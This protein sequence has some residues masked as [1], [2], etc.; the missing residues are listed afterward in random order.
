MLKREPNHREALGAKGHLLVAEGR[1]QEAVSF[2][3]KAAAGGDA[4]L[5][6]ALASARLE[7]GDTRGAREAASRVLATSPN[8]PW[9]LT[10]LGASLV[11][12]GQREEGLR[13]LRRAQAA[14][15]RRLEVWRDLA[16]AF[17]AAGD[18]AAGVECRRRG[19]A[20]AD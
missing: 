13:M 1:P 3:E 14:T 16:R 12:E 19:K 2:L 9:A 17:E 11:K 8:H 7:A 15:P 20:L 18:P 6:V 5:L 10:A 4:D